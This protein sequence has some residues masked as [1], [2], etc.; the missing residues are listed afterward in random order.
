MNDL[1]QV[2]ESITFYGTE[3]VNA[4]DFF[5]ILVGKT[6]SEETH[7]AFSRM[8]L[9]EVSNL[10]K[11]DLLAFEG[12]GNVAAER[13]LAGIGL[14]KCL[15]ADRFTARKSITSTDTAKRAFEY[16]QNL[17]QEHVDV[18]YLDTKNQI[19]SIRN[20]FKGSLN[21]SVSHPREI[22]KHAVKVSAARVM[23]AHNHPSG[24][25]EPSEAD[26]RFTRRIVDAGEM[27]GIEVIDHIIVGDDVI[28]LR[29]E[30]YM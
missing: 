24:N 3:K 21:V 12:I 23:I 26:L 14:G 5:T 16:L 6:L 25:S 18:A 27:L 2:R 30:G 10:T 13:I 8:T 15:K 1:D 20:I 19:I 22:F 7:T 29:D 4:V 9:N 11:E 28:S 17:D